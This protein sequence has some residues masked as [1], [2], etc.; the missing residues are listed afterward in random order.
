MRKILQNKELVKDILQLIAYFM[1]IGVLAKLFAPAAKLDGML[2][3]V[4]FSLSATA[5]I[6][7]V[8]LYAA[9]HI[10]P[11]VVRANNKDF[12]APWENKFIYSKG[13]FLTKPVCSFSIL[14][15]IISF[16]GVGILKLSIQ[17][18]M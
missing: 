8:I 4:V 14:F 6:L 5:V 7:F 11:D 1:L 10:I 12:I 2:M 3:V 17:S 13:Y 9:F 16:V 18:V 15:L